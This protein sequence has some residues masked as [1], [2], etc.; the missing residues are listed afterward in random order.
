MK[1]FVLFFFLTATLCAQI[2][3]RDYEFG[4]AL[5][6]YSLYHFLFDEL[7]FADLSQDKFTDYRKNLGVRKIK[8][9]Y[10]KAGIDASAN[11]DEGWRLVFADTYIFDANGVTKQASREIP[12]GPKNAKASFQF[13]SSHTNKD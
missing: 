7:I 5:G 3:Q 4:R 10:Y 11:S 9:L 12:A 13:I 6:D 1:L 2:R 8:V